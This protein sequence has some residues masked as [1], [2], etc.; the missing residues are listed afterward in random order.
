[1]TTLT[2]IVPGAGEAPPPADQLDS[3]PGSVSG[4]VTYVG[5]PAASVRVVVWDLISTDDGVGAWHPR[6]E[7]V[8]TVGQSVVAGV[9]PTTAPLFPEGAEVIASAA[10]VPAFEIDAAMMRARYGAGWQRLID[11]VTVYCRRTDP[12]E[13]LR[14]RVTAPIGELHTRARWLQIVGGAPG[15]YAFEVGP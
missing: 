6:E 15:S 2:L 4:T 5:G 12:A 8:L 10:P 3:R 7:V 9:V 1:M 11:A 13:W 14:A